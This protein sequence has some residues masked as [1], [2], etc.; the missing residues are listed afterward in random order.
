MSSTPV[1]DHLRIAGYSRQ[2]HNLSHFG[3][4][5]GL[6]RWV[7]SRILKA[8]AEGKPYGHWPTIC[9]VTAG[10]ECELKARLDPRT[11]FFCPESS[12][13]CDQEE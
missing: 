3:A 9:K 8:Q 11:L 4:R 13:K 5:Y 2:Q 12:Q 6:P 7:L 10:L 1:E